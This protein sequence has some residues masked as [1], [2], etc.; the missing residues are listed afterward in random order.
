MCKSETG[1]SE[2]GKNLNQTSVSIFLRVEN[3]GEFFIRP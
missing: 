2:T 1:K 3:L